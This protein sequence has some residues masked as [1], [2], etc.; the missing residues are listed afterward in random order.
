MP[1]HRFVHGQVSEVCNA[2]SEWGLPWLSEAADPFKVL[3]KWRSG[4]EQ[5]LRVRY[6]LH[7]A[8]DVIL[9]YALLKHQQR[10]EAVPLIDQFMSQDNLSTSSPAFLDFVRNMRIQCE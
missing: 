1:N 4:G 8:Q 6:E 10:E 2:L 7:R 5:L 3:Q 9:A